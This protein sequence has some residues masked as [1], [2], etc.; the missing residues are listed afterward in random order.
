MFQSSLTTATLAERITQVRCCPC[1]PKRHKPSS[2]GVPQLPTPTL[3]A[4]GWLHAQK[5]PLSLGRWAPSSKRT[6]QWCFKL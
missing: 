2:G 4:Q 5:Q 3:G 1:N 6:Y